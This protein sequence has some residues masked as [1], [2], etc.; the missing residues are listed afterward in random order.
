MER[1]RHASNHAVI[2]DLGEVLATPVDLYMAFAACMDRP[3]PLVEAAYW[4]HRDGYDRGGTAEEFWTAVLGDL[5]AAA[6]PHLIAD[7][8]EIDTRAWTTLRRDSDDL[9]TTL[10]GLGTRL[11]I[12]S[13]ATREMARRARATAWSAYITDWFFS[14]EMG[15]AKPDPRIYSLVEERLNCAPGSIVFFD[16]REANVRAAQE[17]GWTANL[18]V[19]GEQTVAALRRLAILPMDRQD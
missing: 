17:A 15:A 14:S 12:L 16:D 9:L 2:F 1:S 18:W 5:D 3:D 6:S 13:N 8:T 11:G 10:A 19:S 7:L 4:R